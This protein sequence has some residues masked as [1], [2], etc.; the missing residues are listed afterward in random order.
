[1]RHNRRMPVMAIEPDET[2]ARRRREIAD[3]AREIGALGRELYRRLASMGGHLSGLGGD[4][5]KSVKRYNALI[6]S[7]ESNVMPQARRFSELEVEG[8]DRPLPEFRPIETEVRVP[9]P[10][11]DLDMSPPQDGLPASDQPQL[12][13]AE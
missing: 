5:E 8:A 1:M 4:L 9:R 11:R 13:A 2:Y 10:D 3:N 7:V 6:G 12:P